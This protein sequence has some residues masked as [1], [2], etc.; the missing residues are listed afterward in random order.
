[1]CKIIAEQAVGPSI[2]GSAARRSTM[3]AA[4]VLMLAACTGTYTSATDTA[5]PR[6]RRASD[7][8]YPMDA[9]AAVEGNGD[10][11]GE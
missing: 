11:G 6:D 3:L 4:V 7:L 5:R 9:M 1:M 2:A 10:G 8:P